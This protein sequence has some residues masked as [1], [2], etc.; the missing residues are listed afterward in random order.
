MM[1]TQEVYK[2]IKTIADELC[3]ENKTWLR[4]D[5]AFELKKYGVASD[6]SEVSQLVYEAYIAYNHDGNIAIAFVSNN[7]RTTLI[8]EYKLTACLGQGQREQA[9]DIAESSLQVTSGA[10]DTLQ[11]QIDSNLE[12]A[13]VKGSSAM[14]DIVTGTSGVKNVRSKAS[15]LFDKYS[16]M[17]DAY[18]YAEDNVRSNISDFISLRSDMEATYRE[19]AMRLIDVYGDS[20]KM[21]APTLFDF[22]RVEWLDV[23]SMLK[24]VELEYNKIQDKCGALIAEI[25]DSFRMSLQNSLSAY[26][27]TTN[28]SKSVGLA[29]AGLTM[30]SHYMSSN[31]RTNQLRGDL[32]VL[33][34]SMK[35]D[36][37]R[38][39][40]D[41]ERL[42]VIY[43]TLNDVVIP[44]AN[45][46][47]R[48]AAKLMDSDF[49]AMT[50]ALYASADVR[51]LEE[52]RTDLLRQMKNVNVEINDHLTNIDLYTSLV[53]DISSTLTAKQPCYEEAKS[54]KP[55]K[56]F[57]L[58]NWLTFGVANKNYYRNYAEWD[59]ACAPL[60]REYDNYQ[61]DLK[62]DKEELAS[63]QEALNVLKNNYD[64]LT[65]KLNV[66]SK[67]IRNKVVSTEDLQQK[68][69]K[70]LRSLIVMLKL[71]REIIESK[72]DERLIQTVDI[73][74]L[75]KTTK[76][77]ADIEQNLTEF[78]N[79]LSNNL[80]VD[81]NM[82]KKLLNEIAKNGNNKQI[83]GKQKKKSD[84]QEYSEEDLAMVTDKANETLQQGVALFD[85]I[86][87]LKLQQLHGKIAAAA[88][89]EEF[90]RQSAVFKRYLNQIDNKSA[91]LRQ[92][93]KRI[94]LADN[95]D[96]RKQAMELLS[97][98]SGYSLS[99]QDFAEF[100]KGNKQI[101]L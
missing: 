45:V 81:Q 1:K 5:L 39:K 17:V 43:K 57:F 63:H 48:F 61:V 99:E 27:S 6:N 46:Y 59:A 11:S 56:P 98:F 32:A 30:L 24:H 31:E 66:I 90:A 7:S 78:T 85:S 60:I 91:Y 71:G 54:K 67:E 35:H 87:R 74:N 86:A 92:V 10:L 84:M 64:G 4:A 77:P 21:I 72:L 33:Q 23:D 37:T 42:L 93:F 51:P 100:M 47:L 36:S 15:D 96:E 82:S 75:N 13:L 18:H 50:D 94:N 88:Y 22:N 62:L 2:R 38:I 16:K 80:S 101:E 34:N 53:E 68:M 3:R 95:E 19:Y 52:Q 69:L 89:D 76:L 26:K 20:V 29:M 44:K 9:L 25:S 8:A 40:A 79:I 41:M 49:K 58:I 12:L 65:A 55:S 97:D 28:G 73:P 83:E 70:H 14:A